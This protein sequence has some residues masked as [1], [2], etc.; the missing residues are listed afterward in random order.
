MFLG[1]KLYVD[2]KQNI[3]FDSSSY[4]VELE[5]N[6]D[7]QITFVTRENHSEAVV[8]FPSGTV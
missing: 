1:L 6:K 3:A 8:N 5:I 4:P 7:N 2:R